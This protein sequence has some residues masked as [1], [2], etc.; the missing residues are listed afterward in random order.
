MNF[1][2]SLSTKWLRELSGCGVACELGRIVVLRITPAISW[3]LLLDSWAF[4]PLAFPSQPLKRNLIFEECRDICTHLGFYTI[5]CCPEY[6]FHC[7]HDLALRSL[8]FFSP[9]VSLLSPIF[10][11]LCVEQE[12]KGCK[13]VSSMSISYFSTINS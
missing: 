12:I 5:P 6:H 8:V 10:P 2:S 1:L 13:A 11:A 9:Q 7:V 3:G 4:S